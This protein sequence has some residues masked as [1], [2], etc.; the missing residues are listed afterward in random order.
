MVAESTGGPTAGLSK[1][2][3]SA[4][5]IPNVLNTLDQLDLSFYENFVK[6]EV[7]DGQYDIMKV[8]LKYLIDNYL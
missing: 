4:S 1:E 8:S 5:L 7:K 3:I 6:N 2:G